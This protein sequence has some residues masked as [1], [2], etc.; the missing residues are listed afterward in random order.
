M[1]PHRPSALRHRDRALETAAMGRRLG[2]RPFIALA[3][4]HTHRHQ[5]PPADRTPAGHPSVAANIADGRADD[6]ARL[7]R[8]RSPVVGAFA[9]S[10]SFWPRFSAVRWQSNEPRKSP[11]RRRGTRREPGRYRPPIA[12][13]ASIWYH[14]RQT[15]HRFPVPRREHPPVWGG[16]PDRFLPLVRKRCLLT[17]R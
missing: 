5:S 12:A 15:R 6:L 2:A 3:A 11:S 1:L 13:R 16:A 10:L 9:P 7:C 14:V 17:P 8:G 4:Q